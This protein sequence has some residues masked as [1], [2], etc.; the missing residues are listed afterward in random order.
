VDVNFNRDK[1]IIL[2]DT[3]FGA[4]GFSLKTFED[5]IIFFKEQLF[6]YMKENNIDTIIQLGDILDHRKNIDILL[7]NKLVSEFF[8]E[9]RK[10][11]FKLFTLLGNHDIY[12]N[13][14]LDINLVKF[15]EELYPENVKVFTERTKTIINDQKCY[16]VPWII[17]NTLT[18]NELDDVD[19][20]FG[21]LEI[22]NFE[23]IKGHKDE[24]S[25]LTSGFLKKRKKLKEVFSGHYHLKTSDGFVYYVGTPYQLNWGDYDTKRGFYVWDKNNE[26]EFIEN[27]TSPKFIKIKYNESNKNGRLEIKGLY[28]TPVYYNSGS[29]VDIDLSKHHLKFFVN[30]ADEKKKEYES[31]I[32][33][34]RRKG[35]EFTVTNN[36]EISNLIG[37]D[38]ISNDY[39]NTSTTELIITTIKKE[40]PDLLE[41]TNNLLSEIK[42]ES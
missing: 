39:E 30:N 13:T 36:V 16:F 9:I 34:L 19:I 41:L 8:E 38:Y 32:F 25:I 14:K 29:E 18:T 31:D 4:R 5:Q 1:I 26:L 23:M 20:L 6:P 42:E 11:N 12:Y 2:G 15:F 22:R 7:F 27:I 33:E 10:N 17:G 28:D 21:H 3:H 37:K 40:A 24:K 35:F